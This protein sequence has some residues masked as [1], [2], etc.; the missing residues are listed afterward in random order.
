MKK[1]RLPRKSRFLVGRAT[2]GRRVVVYV[3][4]ARSPIVGPWTLRAVVSTN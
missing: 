4:T 3:G 1:S 2:G